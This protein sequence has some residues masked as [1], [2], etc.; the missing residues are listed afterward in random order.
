MD[1]KIKNVYKTKGIGFFSKAPAGVHLLKCTGYFQEGTT[2][3]G[4]R[5]RDIDEARFSC[6][7][8]DFDLYTN[9]GMFVEPHEQGHCTAFSDEAKIVDGIVTGGEL[10]PEIEINVADGKIIPMPEAKVA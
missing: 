5:L 1:L 7:T 10:L 9:V 4:G 2:T 3:G 8:M 6:D